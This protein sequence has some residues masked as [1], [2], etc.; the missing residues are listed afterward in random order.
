MLRR[1]EY[2]RIGSQFL[3]KQGQQTAKNHFS[4]AQRSCIRPV[5]RQRRSRNLSMIYLAAAALPVS[6]CFRGALIDNRFDGLVLRFGCRLRD[7]FLDSDNL[8]TGV[9][10]MQVLGIQK[11]TLDVIPLRN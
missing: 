6:K 4:A 10:R 9:Q 7:E 2:A 11:I 3:L 5:I 1:K 8:N